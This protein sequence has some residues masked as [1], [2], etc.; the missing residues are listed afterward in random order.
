MAFNE[1]LSLVGPYQSCAV[2]ATGS[3]TETIS[4]PATG[5]YSISWKVEAPLVRDGAVASSL[6]VR[7]RNNTTAT[8]VF[9]GTAG[10]CNGG[11]VWFTATAADVISINLSSTSAADYNPINAVK[12]TFALSSGV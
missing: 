7:I 12:G 6:I 11:Q 2:G 5:D 4:I 8:N 9:L 3:T 1:S 10:A